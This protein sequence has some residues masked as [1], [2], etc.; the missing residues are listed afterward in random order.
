M[1]DIPESGFICGTC[2]VAL[3]GKW[4]D[5][6]VATLHSGV[7]PVCGEERTLANVGDWKWPD[8]RRRGMRD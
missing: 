3:G 1:P 2:A 5:G 8:R 7:C 4:P 6:H